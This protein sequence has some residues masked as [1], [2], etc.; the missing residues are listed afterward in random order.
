M[1]E[2]VT[3]QP[4]SSYLICATPRSGS[5][6]LCEALLNTGLAG[7]PKEYFEALR[8]T[9]LPRRPKE[10]FSGVDDPGILELLGEFSTLDTVPKRFAHGEEYAHYL[11]RV[12][13]EGTTPNGVF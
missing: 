9:G 7:N 6:L 13:E 5:T 12:F 8:E 3:V 4:R 11:A 10:Y 2:E 1:I